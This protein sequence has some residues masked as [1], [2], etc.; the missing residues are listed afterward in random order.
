MARWKTNFTPPKLAYGT[1]NA[2][3]ISGSSEPIGSGLTHATYQGCVGIGVSY[4]VSPSGKLTVRDGTDGGTVGYFAHSDSDASNSY[5]LDLN[6]NADSEATDGYF[7]NFADGAGSIGS[8]R[9][10]STSTVAFNTTSDYRLKEN[11]VD[12]TDGLSRINALKPYKF[13]FIRDEQ[14]RV[15]DGMFAHEVKDIVPIAVMGEKDAV[16]EEGNIDPQTLDY[17]KLVPVMVAAIKE[18]STKVE[19]LETQISGSS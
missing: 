7:I 9:V 13:N 14:D 1:P 18:L 19:T 4:G 10:A 2:F 11:A 6:F 5:I 12:V 15:Q 8:V 16:D 3:A 17:S